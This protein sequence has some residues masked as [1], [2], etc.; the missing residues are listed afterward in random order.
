M[1]DQQQM[2]DD[3]SQ[4]LN[5]LIRVGE[6]SSIN[7]EKCT[8][9]VKFEDNDDL[10]SDELLIVTRGSLYNKDYWMPDINEQVIC[11]FLP[12]GVAQ[13][14]ILASYYSDVDK[15]A[16]NDPDVTSRVF[17][18]GSKLSFNR[19]TSELLVDIVKEIN[20]NSPKVKF[21]T[22]AFEVDSPT[23]TFTGLVKASN[24]QATNNVIAGGDVGDA[25]GSVDAIRD[26][27]NNHAGHFSPTNSTPSNAVTS[28]PIAPSNDNPAPVLSSGSSSSGGSGSGGNTFPPR[29]IDAALSFAPENVITEWV[30][31]SG[32]VSDALSFQP[33]YL[34]R[35]D[36]LDSDGGFEGNALGLVINSN[37]TIGLA[38]SLYT[39]YRLLVTYKH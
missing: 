17:K 7:P 27:F 34:Q 4:L 21:T 36:I 14:F 39:G 8:A 12:I 11:L 23:S 20:I 26:A 1:G 9:R 32:D 33:L 2:N 37:K 28:S 29:G 24:V 35:A 5:Q 25:T 15:P 10:V 38:S 19:R 16:E 13:G 31:I 6:V 18:D 3:I 30:T 22:G